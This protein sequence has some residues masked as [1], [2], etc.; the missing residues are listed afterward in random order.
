MNK[1]DEQIKELFDKL[2]DNYLQ[3]YKQNPN[4]ILKIRIESLFD[5]YKFF[6]YDYSNWQKQYEA[7]K[8]HR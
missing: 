2:M 6:N 5:R 4:G 3:Q 1:I 8:E 7:L